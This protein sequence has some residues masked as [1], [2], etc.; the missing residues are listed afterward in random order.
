MELLELLL[1]GE[2]KEFIKL[3]KEAKKKF[4]PPYEDVAKQYDVAEHAVND[5][6]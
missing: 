4:S 1:K 2:Y 3:V 5:A 6:E